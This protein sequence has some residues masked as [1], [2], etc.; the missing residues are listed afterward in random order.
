LKKI[1]RGVF[2]LTLFLLFMSLTTNADS[3][4][5]KVKYKLIINDYNSGKARVLMNIENIHSDSISIREVDYLGAYKMIESMSVYNG[6]TALDYKLTNEYPTIRDTKHRE[7]TINTAGNNSVTVDYSVIL[8]RAPDKNPN[9]NHRGYVGNGFALFEAGQVFIVPSNVNLD[10]NI[11]VGFDVPKGSN[12]ISTWFEKDGVYYPNKNAYNPENRHT[13]IYTRL[14]DSVAIGNFSQINKQIGITNFKVAM[15]ANW[16]SNKRSGISN[17]LFSL[18]AYYNTLFGTPVGNDYFTVYSPQTNDGIP[19]WAGEGSYSQGTS[20][21]NG[22]FYYDMIAHQIFHRWNGWS[23]GWDPDSSLGS[24]LME[25]NNRYYESR[26]IITNLDQLYKPTSRDVNNLYRSYQAYKSRY[27]PN[28]MIYIN[29]RA[30]SAD[31]LEPEI[32][33]NQGALICLGLDMQI[34]ESTNN[35]KNFD[36]FTRTINQKYGNYNGLITYQEVLDILR[37]I[38]GKDYSGYF[39]DY[40]FGTK[41]LDLD[42]YFSDNDNDGMPNYAELFRG[43]DPN[44][45]DN[46]SNSLT[47]YF[48]SFNSISLGGREECEKSYSAWNINGGSGP[49]LSENDLNKYNLIVLLDYPNAPQ[50]SQAVSQ[51]FSS[52][53]KDARNYINIKNINGK[54]LVYV[55]AES[56]DKL[57]NYIDT[58][59]DITDEGFINFDSI[60]LKSIA[61][62]NPGASQIYKDDTIKLSLDGYYT[63]QNIM[64]IPD[65]INWSISGD[66]ATIDTD[67]VLKA[68]KPGKVSVNAQYQGLSNSM[69]IEIINRVVLAKVTIISD[70]TDKV[71]N[72]DTLKLKLQGTYSD[73][74]LKELNDEVIWKINGDGAAI[75]SDGVISGLKSGSVEVIADVNGVSSSKTIEVVNRV[76]L[77][78]IVMSQSDLTL[79]EGAEA[80]L[81][82]TG[83]YTD[84]TEKEL[85]NEVNWSIDNKDAAEVSSSGMVLGKHQA[86]GVIQAEINGIKAEC[87]IKVV[88]PVKIIKLTSSTSRIGIKNKKTSQIRVYAKYNNG[89]NEDITK[90]IN[91]TY[92]RNGIVSIN[93]NGKITAVNA[94]KVVITGRTDENVHRFV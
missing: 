40:V 88:Q 8:N 68:V 45:K 3:E 14:N 52:M 77:K 66:S 78:S 80:A 55:Y 81:R 16:D 65:N 35:K 92:S 70:D 50:K 59:N 37:E 85:T 21:N 62:N 26:S 94:G 34:R 23:W 43:T 72:G 9:E 56:K 28:N 93:I 30:T 24:L 82:V 67:G 83:L 89:V 2:I 39:N 15:P 4:K 11:E 63:D 91:W 90:R 87:N 5:V 48:K 6:A 76:E 18:L 17:S 1:V 61:I 51:L 25:A 38:T 60:E 74:T 86:G 47:K 79:E 44:T 84:G 7:W 46:F 27:N 57:L 33:Y 75:S 29:A 32:A 73:G 71:F 20:E 41:F 64:K 42:K 31:P 10:E 49:S 36:D 22:E 53:K 13:T 54:L 69:D 12:I 19:V 58:V